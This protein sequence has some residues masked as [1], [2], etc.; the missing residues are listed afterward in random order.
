MRGLKLDVVERWL[1]CKR[2]KKNGKIKRQKGPGERQWRVKQPGLAGAKISLVL[3]ATTTN[4]S[5][6]LRAL[7]AKSFAC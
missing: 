3:L 7:M 2:G 4:L 5:D 6:L 1:C